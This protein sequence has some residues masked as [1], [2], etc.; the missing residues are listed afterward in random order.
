MQ[1]KLSAKTVW[2]KVVLFLKEHRQIA[3]HVACGDITD[4][5][6]DGNK[7]ILNVF[8]GT[9]VN[10]LND[11]RREIENALR[12]QGLEHKVVVNIKETQL[13]KSEQDIKR[14][15]A[16][17]DDEKIIIKEFKPFGGR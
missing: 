2:G 4:V 7:L 16:V 17:F 14:L 15:K 11:G 3:L 9:L 5:E 8:D 10:M 13:S 6:L 12:W 1:G